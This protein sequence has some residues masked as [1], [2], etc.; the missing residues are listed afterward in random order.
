MQARADITPDFQ[1]R[2]KDFRKR[3]HMTQTEFA[4]MCGLSKATIYNIEH[5]A[6]PIMPTTKAAVEAAL[7]R[8]QNE[9]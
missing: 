5:G 6:R 8:C 1:A 7:E 4:E 3:H 9:N 2:I